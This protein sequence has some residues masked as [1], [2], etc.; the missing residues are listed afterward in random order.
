MALVQV[1]MAPEVEA[2]LVD[3]CEPRVLKE[4][5]ITSDRSASRYRHSV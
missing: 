3:L 2:S 5:G 4:E 1:M